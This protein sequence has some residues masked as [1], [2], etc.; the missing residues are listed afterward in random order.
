MKKYITFII[1]IF[2]I[3]LAGNTLAKTLNEYITE[4][5][6]TKN[7]YEKGFIWVDV[8]FL[9]LAVPTSFP[10]S[11]GCDPDGQNCKQYTWKEYCSGAIVEDP[12]SNMMIITL[13]RCG[14]PDGQNR[15]YPPPET[16]INLF[17]TTFGDTGILPKNTGLAKRTEYL[18]VDLQL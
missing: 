3:G 8:S 2:V 4:D 10:N 5:G 1:L 7:D 9:A 14:H 12:E 6:Y 15:Q 16:V 18:P 11:E 13:D 17:L